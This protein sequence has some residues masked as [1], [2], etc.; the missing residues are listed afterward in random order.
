MSTLLTILV[1]LL[2]VIAVIVAARIALARYFAIRD[3]KADVPMFGGAVRLILWEQ[4]DGL[5]LLRYKRVSEVIQGDGGTRFIFPIRG[6]EVRARVSLRYRMLTWEDP[7]VL[8]RESIQVHIKVALW[9]KVADLEKY[10]FNID[11]EI[12]VEDADQKV[13][14]LGAAEEWLK[15]LTESTLRTLVSR[16]SVA[17]LV[18]ANASHYLHVDPGRNDLPNATGVASADVLAG[19]LAKGLEPKALEYGLTIQ[20]LEI[21]DIGLANEIQEAVNRVWK[22]SLLPAQTEQEMKARQIELQRAAEVLGI[23]A[24]V[25]NE[26]LKNFQGASFLNFPQFLETFMSSLGGKLGA[27]KTQLAGAD[28][29]RLPSGPSSASR[30]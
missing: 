18:S 8:T 15:L 24:V 10:V 23:D 13:G 26:V 11:P 6:E 20:R 12:H 19:D 25:M 29:Q 30:A 28:R 1:V 27:P 16:T 22:A 5:I 4:S 21:Q 2:M 14:I 7:A 9:W 3:H 17:L